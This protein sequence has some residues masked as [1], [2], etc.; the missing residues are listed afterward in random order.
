MGCSHGHIPGNVNFV[1]V[2]VHANRIAEDDKR[3]DNSRDDPLPGCLR[4]P[5]KPGACDG[6]RGAEFAELSPVGNCMPNRRC[7]PQFPAQSPISCVPTILNE[8]AAEDDFSASLAAN[9]LCDEAPQPYD[10]AASPFAVRRNKLCI[11]P[12]AHNAQGYKEETQ[13]YERHDL[14]R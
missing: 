3:N 13:I 14:P 6:F 5:Q 8:Y 10:D 1:C 11:V 12:A 7:R 2:V 4:Y 9:G